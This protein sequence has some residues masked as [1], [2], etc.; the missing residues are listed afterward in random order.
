M[1]FIAAT[2]TGSFHYHG[3]RYDLAPL[4]P[5]EINPDH[6]LVASSGLERPGRCHSTPALL[7]WP[8][9]PEDRPTEG[10]RCSLESKP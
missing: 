10:G 6:I 8:S 4:T 5:P 2:T 9:L 7:P 1:I 3:A